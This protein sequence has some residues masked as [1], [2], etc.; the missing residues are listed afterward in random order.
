L[1]SFYLTIHLALTVLGG[2]CKGKSIGLN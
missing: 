1:F 2:S